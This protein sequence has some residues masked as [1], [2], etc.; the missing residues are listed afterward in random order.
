[1][2]TPNS[3]CEDPAADAIAIVMNTMKAV[4]DPASACPPRGGGST[5]V[6]F[7]TFAGAPLGA[8]DAHS[9]EGCEAP[10]LWVRL[11]SRFRTQ[12]F[13]D[14]QIDAGPCRGQR[15]IGLEIGVGRCSSAE[16]ETD[17]EELNREAA[18]GLDDSWRIETALCYAS[19]AL[20]AAG[21]SAATDSIV[22]YGPE[23]GVSAWSG[24]LFVGL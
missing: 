18:I 14:E 24:M 12:S 6:R 10:F 5:E 1:M 22:P 7:F 15:A 23:G 11:D 9:H 2:T 19:S 16:A 21:Y 4:F 3:A 17:W 13:P 20:T 8:W